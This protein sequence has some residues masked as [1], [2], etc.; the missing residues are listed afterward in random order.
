LAI[1]SR[2]SMP[3]STVHAVLVR[4]RLNRLSHIDIRIGEPIRSYEH[5]HPGA[6]IHVDVKR[7]GNIPDGGGWRFVGRAQGSKNRRTTDGVT[8]SGSHDPTLGHSFVH[9]VI[10]GHSRVAYA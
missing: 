7:L 9:T 10:D 6:R 3:A 5:D 4:C 1:A 8:R 2:L